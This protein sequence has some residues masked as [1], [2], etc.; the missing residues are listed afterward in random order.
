MLAFRDHL[1][2]DDADRA[3]YQRP[4]MYARTKGRPWVRKPPITGVQRKM[5]AYATI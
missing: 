5:V 2:V 4:A 3:C 1:R